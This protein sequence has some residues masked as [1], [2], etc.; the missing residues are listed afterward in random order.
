MTRVLVIPDIHHRHI[1]A[2]KLIETLKY[3]KCILLGDYFDNFGDITQEAYN[4]AVWLKEKVLPNP[5]IIPLIGN[6]DVNYFFPWHKQFYCSGF[7]PEKRDAIRSVL[8]QDDIRKFKFFHVED[9]W[10]YSHAGLTVPVWKDMKLVS[11]PHDPSVESVHD[12]FVRVFD[13]WIRKT[14]RDIDLM[15]PLPLLEAGWDRGGRAA[16]GGIIWVD[17]SNFASIKGVNQFVGHTPHKVPEVHLQ[18]EDGSYTKKPVTEYWRYK[19][20]FDK[21]VVSKNFALDTHSNHYAIVTDGNVEIWD[22]IY[23]I[24]I[25]KLVE[26]HIPESPMNRA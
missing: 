13:H 4:T 21:G 23:E 22:A 7:T 20:N 19:K 8:T 15:N 5:K 11:E 24:P 2:Q 26:F 9:K 6:H 1:S 16:N 17:W 18:Y 12:H 3:D 10:V 14:V 25:K